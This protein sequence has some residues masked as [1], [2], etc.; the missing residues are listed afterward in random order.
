M[1]LAV[2]LWIVSTM[3]LVSALIV[4]W[5]D[6]CVVS[7]CTDLGEATVSWQTEQELVTLFQASIAVF[8][9]TLLGG[10]MALTYSLAFRKRVSP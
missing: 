7:I 5:V 8:V 2:K 9:I 3:S 6:P 1:M 4:N 10:I